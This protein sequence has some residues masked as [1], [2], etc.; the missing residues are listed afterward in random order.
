LIDWY[1]TDISVNEGLYLN[2]Y[3]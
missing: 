3:L 2:F 1:A